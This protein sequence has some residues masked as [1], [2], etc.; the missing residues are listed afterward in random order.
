METVQKDEAVR[1]SRSAFGEDKEV[2]ET[3][4]FL[5]SLKSDPGTYATRPDGP[6]KDLDDRV[7][8]HIR[9]KGSIGGIEGA[10]GDFVG[11]TAYVEEVFKN[12]DGVFSKLYGISYPYR[13]YADKEL[14]DSVTLTKGVVFE[15]LA[16][17]P[18]ILFAPHR[19]KRW[20]ARVCLKS[21]NKK[22][23]HLRDFKK[24]IR[25]LMRVAEKHVKPVS[26][27]D[28]DVNLARCFASFFE[29][30]NA[31]WGPAQ[32]A[33]SE[34]DRTNDPVREVARLFD[35]MIERWNFEALKR[36]FRFMKRIVMF[37]LW[38]SPKARRMLSE[39]VLDLNLNEIRP[40]ESDIY[41]TLNRRDYNYRGESYEKRLREWNRI[42]EEKGHVI[43][44][45]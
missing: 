13:G 18:W 2:K 16:A 40:D 25:E 8:K 11:A 35:L 41:Y 15:T 38:V 43:L 27:G 4:N 44:N 1:E 31:Y 30:D 14:M 26:V 34:L 21:L 19:T 23:P 20:A 22:V 6:K 29:F 33:L 39:A 28:S 5:N 36:K 9:E 12:E 37:I 24:G 3:M 17:F 32:D 10:L 7:R 42:N 45:I